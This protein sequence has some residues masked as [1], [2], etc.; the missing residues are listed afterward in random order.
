MALILVTIYIIFV[1]YL[2]GV[3]SALSYILFWG[4]EYEKDYPKIDY[5]LM[6]KSWFFRNPH[7]KQK[8]RK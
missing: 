8:K 5:D 4:M 6:W 2:I 7:L 3:G 1:I